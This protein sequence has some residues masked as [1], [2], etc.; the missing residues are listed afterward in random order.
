[1]NLGAFGVLACIERSGE[2]IESLDDLRG[3]CATHPAIGYAMVLC[4]LSLLGLPP[5]LG[6]WG[7]LYLFTAGIAAGEITLIVLLGIT[8]A[9]GALYYLR[10]A[11]NPFLE[12]PTDRE[13]EFKPSTSWTRN[14]ATLISAGG[15][16]ALV[17]FAA[18]LMAQADSATRGPGAGEEPSQPAAIT[19]PLQQT[20][21]APNPPTSNPTDS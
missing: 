21:A 1:M 12:P 4:S 13:K 6:F 2:E 18:L 3:L 14:I 17:P 11:A 10:L 19:Q 15:V 5:L 16:V 8:S 9:I 7:K 20:S